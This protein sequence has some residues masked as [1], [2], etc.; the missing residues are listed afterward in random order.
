MSKNRIQL[1]AAIVVF[2]IVANISQ[3]D[4]QH[5][6]HRLVARKAI[7]EL[8]PEIKP[9]FVASQMEF[10][11]SAVEPGDGWTRDRAMSRRKRWHTVEVDATADTQNL[12]ARMRAFDAF[13]RNERDAQLLYR[14]TSGRNGGRLPWA[15]AEIH[16]ELIDAFRSGDA[17]LA[18]QQAGYLAHFVTDAAN[19]FRVT[20]NSDGQLTENSTFG[21]SRSVHPNDAD[22]SVRERFNVAL[23]SKYASAYEAHIRINEKAATRFAEPLS[24]AFELIE[25]S[26]SAVDHITKVD[27]EALTAL[28]ITDADS[29][30]AN[31][32]DYL[33][34]LDEGCGDIAITQLSAATTTTAQLINAAWTSAGKPT[35]SL[36]N[37]ATSTSGK[38]MPSGVAALTGGAYVGSKNS[39]VFHKPNCRF[40]KQISPENV[41][42]YGS[43]ADARKDARRGCRSCKPE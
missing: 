37:K 16:A 31:R 39:N 6:A 38:P 12:E 41:V 4:E 27:H 9:V 15:I 35:I 34:A 21:S 5:V 19:P 17:M 33:K 13:P 25:L 7:E 2:L 24:A 3:A 26:L 18:I 36:T 40:A 11:K 29:L 8:A 14:R 32:T 10:T 42:T 28:G 20:A 43:P 23:L 30:A 22:H 1:A